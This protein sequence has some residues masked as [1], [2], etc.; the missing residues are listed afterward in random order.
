M[1]CC[2]LLLLLFLPSSS[3]PVLFSSSLGSKFRMQWILFDGESGTVRLA[4]SMATSGFVGASVDAWRS[5]HALT[6]PVT[7]LGNGERLLCEMRG[8]SLFH[9][10]VLRLKVHEDNL[11]EAS[12]ICNIWRGQR[13]AGLG[14]EKH[15]MMWLVRN[16]EFDGT[17]GRGRLHLITPA[18]E[19][20]YSTR[21][22]FEPSVEVA[23]DYTG[24][25]LGWV[26]DRVYQHAALLRS[27]NGE[28]TLGL[29]V[30]RSAFSTSQPSGGVSME[31]RNA[32]RGRVH[33]ESHRIR[34]AL[35]SRCI[36]L[37]KDQR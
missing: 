2:S 12:V 31:Y 27:C 21:I 18:P 6:C 1:V 13:F 14:I 17:Y 22:T 24:I 36:G 35:A 7:C 10:N 16:A 32:L 37:S 23:G 25:V 11:D 34:S 9:E 29:G 5:R 19:S 15:R 28:K 30:L 20:D 4:Q 26:G 33:L 8:L 3:L